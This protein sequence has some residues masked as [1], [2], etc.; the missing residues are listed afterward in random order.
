MVDLLL[1]LVGLPVAATVGGWL[2]A[3]R[4]PDGLGRARLE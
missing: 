4:E 1:I 2:L 3:A